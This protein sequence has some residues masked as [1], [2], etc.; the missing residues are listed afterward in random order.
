MKHIILTYLFLLAVAM[1]CFGMSF[2]SVNI[3]TKT[4]AAMK[5]AYLLR[6]D[7]EDANLEKVKKILEHYKSASIATAGIYLT[8]Y[9]DRKALQKVENWAAPRRITTTGV[10]KGLLESRFT[11]SS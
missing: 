2:S 9:S 4:E 1:P 8:K 6:Q 7:V 3:D 5:S 10:S 11:G